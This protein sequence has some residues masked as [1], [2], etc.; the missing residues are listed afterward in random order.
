MKKADH[1]FL[2]SKMVWKDFNYQTIWH[3]NFHLML[4]FLF[5]F[6]SPSTVHR[7]GNFPL[8]TQSP[9]FPA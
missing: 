4:P 1:M 3:I 5:L 6:N 2:H 8:Q 9:G 7:D